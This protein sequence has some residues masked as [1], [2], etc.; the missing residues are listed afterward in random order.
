MAPLKND[1]TDADTA[2]TQH[3]QAHN[4]AATSINDLEASKVAKAGDT[5]T[6]LLQLPSGGAGTGGLRIGGDVDLYR[7]A[8]DTL[9]TDDSLVVNGNL[10]VNGTFSGSGASGG[11]VQ[12]VTSVTPPPTP[13]VNVVWVDLS[14]MGTY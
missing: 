3:P 2:A 11:T 13:A 14:G 10:T 6:G 12:V 9:K 8:A 4:D 1:W 5:M 7:S